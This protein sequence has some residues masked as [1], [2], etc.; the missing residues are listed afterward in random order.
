LSL[1]NGRK[2]MWFVVVG[3]YLVPILVVCHPVGIR[4]SDVIPSIEEAT[5]A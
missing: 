4:R 3:P 2:S 1:C 5:G